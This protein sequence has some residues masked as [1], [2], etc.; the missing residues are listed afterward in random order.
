MHTAGT[1]LFLALLPRSTSDQNC[2]TDITSGKDTF[3]R[4]D[5]TSS[6]YAYSNREAPRPGASFP[7]PS[8][9]GMASLNQPT[10]DRLNPQRDRFECGL[11]EL[12]TPAISEILVREAN[13]AVVYT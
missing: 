1:D 11:T 9:I 7:L 12:N 13:L 6:V 10:D 8:G 2:F 4:P 3:A 5:Y